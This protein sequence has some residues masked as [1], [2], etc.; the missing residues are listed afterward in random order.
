[1]NSVF[2]EGG[3]FIFFLLTGYTFRP[4]L[5]NPY[6]R[7]SQDPDEEDPDEVEM[8]DVVVFDQ[9]KMDRVVMRNTTRMVNEDEKTLLSASEQRA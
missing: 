8:D 2:Q 9:N 4:T 6:L 1:M 3:T 7:L 5:E